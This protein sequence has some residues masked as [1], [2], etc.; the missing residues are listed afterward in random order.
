[1]RKSAFTI[2]EGKKLLFSQ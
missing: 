1:L 2:K